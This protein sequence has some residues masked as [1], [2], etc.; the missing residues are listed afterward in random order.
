LRCGW[1]E[2]ALDTVREGLKHRRPNKFLLDL[3]V[4]VALE[5][6]L[7]EEAAKYLE[8]LKRFNED[9]DYHHRA[10]TLLSAQGRHE[11][12]LVHAE[13]A[14]RQGRTRFEVL[15]KRADI[16]IDLERFDEAAR[17][18]DSLDERFSVEAGR[19]D[20]RVGLRC[21]LL[22]RERK[23]RLAEEVLSQIGDQETPQS[24]ALRL[25]IL[26]QKVRD[27]S[28]SPGERERALKL[29]TALE[30]QRTSKTIV[31]S[32]DDAPELEETAEDEPDVVGGEVKE[33]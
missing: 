33:A 23:W 4:Q 11:E 29:T 12:A 21:K 28:V 30:H 24:R 26:A 17:E 3:G 5:A 10:A 22:I 13:L 15:A 16:L 1:V 31:S 19:H 18:I 32:D 27:P 8:D 7:V 14:V 6:G 9:A 25:D 2:Q 20:A